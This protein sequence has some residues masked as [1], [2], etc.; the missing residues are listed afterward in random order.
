M[1]LLDKYSNRAVCYIFLLVGSNHET[2]FYVFFDWILKGK[3][4]YLPLRQFWC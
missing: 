1:W 2:Y 4:L 3:S